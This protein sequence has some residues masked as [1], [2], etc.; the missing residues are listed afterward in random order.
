[1]NIL[2]VRVNLNIW[3]CILGVSFNRGNLVNIL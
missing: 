3:H 2:W 1:M